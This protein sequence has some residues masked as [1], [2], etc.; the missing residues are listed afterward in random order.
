MRFL[1]FVA[2][3]FF[4]GLL[5]TRG[6]ARADWEGKMEITLPKQGKMEGMVHMKNDTLRV[7]MEKPLAISSIVNAAKGTAFSLVH[8]AKMII[9]TDIKGADQQ[10][11]ACRASDVDACLA[12][13]GY[14]P[15]GEEMLGAYACKI[16]EA[17]MMRK[18]KPLTL[19]LWRPTAMKDVPALKIWAKSAEGEV[20]TELK[21]VKEKSQSASYFELPKDYR[22]MGKMKLPG[23]A[24]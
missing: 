24:M 18:G 13:L 3:V 9:E 22:N 2:G 17:K 1:S 19:R 6:G 14:K 11:P 7:D 5:S 8:A 4:L 12:R 20:L 21:D 10:I 16:Y 23:M 15:V